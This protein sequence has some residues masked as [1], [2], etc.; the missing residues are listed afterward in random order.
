MWYG[1]WLEKISWTDHV[2]TKAVLQRIKEERNIL[3]TIKRRKA[4]CIGHSLRRN[5]V[6]KHIIQGK[7]ERRIKG[8][9]RWRRRREQ[10]LGYL[11][12]RILEIESGSTRSHCVEN[13][14]WK[15][16]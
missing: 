3:R 6:L 12:E 14:L 5:G 15:K 16:V 9:G 10:L 2:K 13:S 7:V 8:A 11:K 1:R 4:D